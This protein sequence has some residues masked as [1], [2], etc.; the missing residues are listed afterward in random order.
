M[1]DHRKIERNLGHRFS[2]TALLN[3]A[4]TH[5]SHNPIHNERLEF[6]G[7]SVLNCAIA[8]ALF[9]RFPQLAE[10]ELSRLRAALVNKNVLHEIALSVE[11]GDALLLG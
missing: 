7:D 6:L 10:G 3:E 5:R 9:Q 8:A 2:Q 1:T 4:L 11:L